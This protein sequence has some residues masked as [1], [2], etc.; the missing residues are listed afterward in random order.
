MTGGIG[1]PLLEAKSE[2]ARRL[3]RASRS[4][5][6]A[7]NQRSCDNRNHRRGRSILRP[8]DRPAPGHSPPAS[9]KQITILRLARLGHIGLELEQLCQCLLMLDLSPGQASQT[10]RAINALAGWRCRCQAR[11]FCCWIFA[12]SK[13]PSSNRSSPGCCRRPAAHLLVTAALRQLH[14]QL[15]PAALLFQRSRDGDHVGGVDGEIGLLLL[16][17]PLPGLLKQGFGSGLVALAE[18][19]VRP[20]SSRARIRALGLCR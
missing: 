13:R 11:H 10:Q 15:I 17:S 14:R 12:S 20:R 19:K 7:L 18:L 8:A 2:T 5:S 16:E 1:R 6:L 3:R 4:P 9:L